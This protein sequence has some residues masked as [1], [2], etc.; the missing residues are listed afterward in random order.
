M[1]T[2]R[3]VYEV[4]DEYTFLGQQMKNVY[5]YQIGPALSFDAQDLA[6]DFTSVCLPFIRPVH[7]NDVIHT[8]VAVRNLFDPAESGEVLHSLAGT[9]AA[10]GEALPPFTA[11]AFTL[12]RQTSLTRSGKKRV[13][14]GGESFQT[15]GTWNGA[16]LTALAALAGQMA[17]AI[18]VTA[19]ER[20]F[21]VIVKRILVTA[22]E[23]R[24]P[25]TQAEADINGVSGGLVS[26]LMT[27]QNT[28]K[29]GVGS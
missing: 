1:S 11:A 4:V 22:G 7:A 28:R 16:L 2:D 24:L 13:Y 17:E 27:T 3:N 21:P 23:Y 29:I 14:A 26:S 5:F 15:G 25:A 19:V 6:E 18:V 10:G 9:L 20:W 12:A 8:R